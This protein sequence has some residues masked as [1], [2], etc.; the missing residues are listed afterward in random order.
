MLM[1]GVDGYCW[2]RKF[3]QSHRHNSMHVVILSVDPPVNRNRLALHHCPSHHPSTTI[4]TRQPMEAAGAR[5]VMTTSIV[6][7]RFEPLYG[8]VT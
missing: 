8:I 2:R 3:H 1:T 5:H 6:I 4:C 7:G